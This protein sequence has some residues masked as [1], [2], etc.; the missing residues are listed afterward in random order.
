MC[1]CYLHSGSLDVF[2]SVKEK[3]LTSSVDLRGR[4]HVC[5]LVLFSLGLQ[6]SFL[7]FRKGKVL[8][9]KTFSIKERKFDLMESFTWE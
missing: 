7:S 9:L 6:S 2:F 1:A 8:I 5:V 4:E 3:A